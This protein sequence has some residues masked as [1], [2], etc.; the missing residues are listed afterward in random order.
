[1]YIG[2]DGDIDEFITRYI[3]NCRFIVS[4]LNANGIERYARKS[5][6][7]FD[8]IKDL[9]LQQNNELRTIFFLNL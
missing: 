8:W 6:L 2:Y 3:H 5:P 7:H 9:L 1:M 4:S